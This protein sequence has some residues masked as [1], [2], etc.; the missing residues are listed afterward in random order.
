MPYTVYLS[1]E[2]ELD[3]I[4]AQ[5]WYEFQ[6]EKLGAELILCVEE[7]LSSIAGNPNLYQKRYKNLRVAYISRF[8]YGI[9]YLVE[10]NSVLVQGIFHMSRDPRAW[11]ER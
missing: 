8:P 11:D 4:E 7:A 6:R 3:L 10:G 9:H 2:A 1:K 5:T